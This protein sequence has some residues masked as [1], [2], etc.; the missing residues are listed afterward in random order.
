VRVIHTS[1]WHIGRSFE[2]LSLE[3][4][5]RAFGAWLA[6]AVV[7]HRV[8][9][10]V[11][12]GDLFDRA[13]P[14]GEAV[15]CFVDLLEDLRRTGVALVAIP[16]NHDSATRLSLA[17]AFSQGAELYLETEEVD[18]PEPFVLERAGLRVGVL[19]VPFRDPLIARAPR[20]DAAGRP[21]TRTHEHVLAD[22][23]EVGRERLAHLEVD[24]TLCVAH[25]FVATAEVSDSERHP[26]GGADVVSASCFDG[27]SYVALGHLHRPQWIARPS[28]A[29]SGSPL[30]YSFSEAHR[31]SVRLVEFSTDGTVEVT[32]IPI[33][34]GR[35]VVTLT[36]TLADLL[37]D[38]NYER[39]RDCFVAARLSDAGYLERPLERLQ[40]RFPFAVKVG[41]DRAG[42]DLSSPEFLAAASDR[43]PAVVIKAFLGNAESGELDPAVDELVTELLG[44]SERELDQ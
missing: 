15:A 22:A 25:A 5:Q 7:E 36:G 39:Y 37:E 16:G 24:A 13:A 27:F 32:E 35:A 38:P 28:L 3:D 9:V 26:I 20:P 33:P 34:V 30:P 11:I 4:D 1:D 8:D 18:Y 40:E 44:R 41:Y 17:G 14:S 31:K 43:D 42:I 10:V 6:E 19:A 12:A 2:R 23:L 29:Y 21:R